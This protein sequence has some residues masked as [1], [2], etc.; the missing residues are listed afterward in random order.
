MELPPDKLKPFNGCD[1]KKVFAYSKGQATVIRSLRSNPTLMNKQY[2]EDKEWETLIQEDLPFV[3]QVEGESGFVLLI[4]PRILRQHESSCQ[5]LPT[6]RVGFD[7]KSVS[8]R[9]DAIMSEEDEYLGQGGHRRTRVLP[10]SS[11]VFSRVSKAFHA[12]RSI[13]TAISRADVPLFSYENITMQGE[14]DG[15]EA[16]VYNCRSTNAWGGDLAMTVTHFPHCQLSFGILFGCNDF[17]K[18][19]VV[20]RLEQTTKESGHSLLLPGVFAELERRRHHAIFDS[21]ITKLES[22]LTGPVLDGLLNSQTRINP[23]VEVKRSVYIDML[24]LKHGLISWSKQLR[25]ILSHAE[26]LGT[27]FMNPSSLP[28]ACDT[29]ELT[30]EMGVRVN[31]CHGPRVTR[32]KGGS[33]YTQSIDSQVVAHSTISNS[34]SRQHLKRAQEDLAKTNSRIT[35]RL[36][37]ILED[38][39]D[40]IRECQT[41][42]D[43]LTM[44]TQL[45]QSETSLALALAASNDS[46]HMR[47]IALVTMVFLP[48]TFFASIFSMT[49]FDWQAGEGESTVSSLFWIYIAFSVFATLATLLAYYLLAIRPKRGLD[50]AV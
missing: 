21:G 14:L 8:G 50:S 40:K 44:T 20:Q 13:A 10:F 24:H 48:G 47:T 46:R 26:T 6:S 49:F 18:R 19:Y 17:Q 9:C 7:E 4:T 41:R 31:L 5:N 30:E 35:R 12:H 27:E 15:V 45:S 32:D 1:L 11:S 28:M 37:T 42:F 43:G 25:K 39:S 34:G 38:Y 16:R 2:Q 3:N 36:E 22:V 23:D 29:F 33:Y